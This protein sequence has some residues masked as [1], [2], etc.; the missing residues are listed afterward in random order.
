M[1]S[2]SNAHQCIVAKLNLSVI[3]NPLLK[4]VGKQVGVAVI[5]HDEV[6]AI[7]NLVQVRN[8][9]A[10]REAPFSAGMMA[11]PVVGDDPVLVRLNVVYAQ[12]IARFLL[13][14]PTIDLDCRLGDLGSIVRVE[15]IHVLAI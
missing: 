7:Q 8:L 14:T 2:E 15:D 9:H 6:E 4:V 5:V 1:R 12:R 10:I 13:E 3:V 11:V